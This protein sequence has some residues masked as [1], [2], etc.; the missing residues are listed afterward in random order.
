MD[1]HPTA[2]EWRQETVNLSSSSVSGKPNVMFKFEFTM[3]NGNNIFIDDINIDG[4][5][6]I[7]EDLNDLINLS[8]MPNPATENTIMSFTL[9]QSRNVK[10]N[11]IDVTGRL[12]ETVV[13]TSLS[14]G[15]YSYDIKNPGASGVY[16]LQLEVDNYTSTKKVIFTN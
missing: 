7:D 15:N 4:I 3:D 1:N 9:N 11:L 6:G 12:V 16:F 8:L 10:V 2:S 14:S 5:V 13:Q